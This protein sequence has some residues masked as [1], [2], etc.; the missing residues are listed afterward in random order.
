MDTRQADGEKQTLVSAIEKAS[1]R[2]FQPSGDD[3]SRSEGQRE[4]SALLSRTSTLALMSA[5]SKLTGPDGAPPWL[6]VHLMDILTLLPQ[7][8]DGVRSTLEFVFSV[9][10]SSTLRAS[11]AP[12]L[13]KQGANITMEA[14][15]LATNLLSAPP[16]TVSPEEW[17]P[18]IAPQLL[19]LLDGK[20]G[21]DLVKA[22]AY[23]I[24]FGVLGRRQFGAPGSAGWKAF[25]APMLSKI[26]ASLSTQE[27]AKKPVVFSAGPDEVV[28]LRKETVSVEADELHT[29]LKRLSSLL[30]SH[31][32]PGL[33]KRLLG[34]LML[35]MWTISSWPPVNERFDERYRRPATT[36]LQI[37]LKIAGSPER[38]QALLKNLLVNGNAD[39]S[40]TRWVYDRVGDS[41]LQVKQLRDGTN[42]THLTLDLGLLEAKSDAYV[43]LLQSVAT[44]SDISALFLTLFRGSFNPTK[45]THEIRITPENDQQGDPT[46]QLA[47]AKVLQKMMEKLSDRLVSNWRQMIELV[48][49]IL[50]ESQISL[51]GPGDDATPV[52]LS[53]LNLVVAAPGFQRSMVRADLLSSI[54]DS[55]GRI[56]KAPEADVSQT[57]RNLSLLLKYRDA[58]DDPSERTTAPTD[59]QVEDRKTY[60]L[61]ISY[62]TQADS[63]PP[64]R[65][66]GLNLLSGLIRAGSPILD[67]QATLV[68]LSSLL[69]ESEDYVNLTVVRL[70]TQLADRHPR[71]TVKELLDHYVDADERE[72][73]DTRLRFGEALLQVLQRLGETFAG[74]I[75]AQ[76]G[77]ALLFLAGRRPRR[78]K[79]EARQRRADRVREVKDRADTARDAR[80]GPATGVLGNGDEDEDEDGRTAE[81]RARDDLVAQIVAGWESRRGAEDMRVRASALSILAAAAE[82]NAPGLGAPLAAA[83]VDLCLGVLALERGPEAGILRRAAVVFI[84]H[85]ARAL[86]SR[87]P[88]PAVVGGRAASPFG[89]GLAGMGGEK[90]AEVRAALA[91]VADTDTDGLA[92]QH[93]QDVLESLD[94]WR[95]ARL[96]PRDVDEGGRGPGLARLAGLNLGAG[97]P[98]ARLPPLQEQGGT[99]PRIE[100]VE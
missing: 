32:N 2:A 47:E 41:D 96:T 97:S 87:G 31:P 53:L 23:V 100:E 38:F 14:L 84:L 26:N 46:V 49:E 8:P 1:A 90:E 81:Q 50:A 18:G 10:P 19:A 63:P 60:N 56:S 5:L 64:V 11:D 94:N 88:G 51:E 54:E 79:T 55:L 42:A 58:I 15:K 7:R 71:S 39:P 4:L 30:D 66:E 99:R 93:A 22:A 70:F 52:A 57:A 43:Q 37:F 83:A 82:T 3:A 24:G 95:L 21:Q 34:P 92:R 17:F 86:A 36:L 91:Y 61:A 89:F 13:Q 59:R 62:I 44:E 73:V 35:P 6:R 12:T 9:H 33:T 48:C 40:R 78:P 74:E 16:A 72:T 65:S 28:D 69:N 45:A 25:A 75:A 80:Q 85:L 27:A 29:A 76:V 68:L 77:Q 98:A 67:I 20:D